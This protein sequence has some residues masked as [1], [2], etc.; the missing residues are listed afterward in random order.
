MRKTTRGAWVLLAA[1]C[2]GD[3]EKT[4]QVSSQF[5]DAT[6][7]NLKARA[8]IPAADETVCVRVDYVGRK[9]LAANPQLGLKP[10][11]ATIRA[12]APELFHVEQ[13]VVYV[14]DG[15]VKQLPREADLA[16]VLSLELARM[17]AEREARVKQEM[18][19]VDPRPPIQ[20]PI[21]NSGQFPV[22][23]MVSTVEAAKHDLAAREARQPLAR[24]D[25]EKVARDCLEKAGYQRVDL[26][27]IQPAVAA[28]GRN[29]S[30]ERQIRGVVTPHAWTPER[31]PQ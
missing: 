19:R 24:V 23:D 9:V 13:K 8:P 22:S 31:G 5:L 1:G 20:V 18:R 12:D 29:A 2:L 25:A 16:A 3:G 14:T 4:A 17:V 26:D 21:G 28:A 30:L 6:P 27:Q 15:L 7:T 11:F 10:I